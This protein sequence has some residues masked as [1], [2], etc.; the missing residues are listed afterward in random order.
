MRRFGCLL[1]VLVVLAVGTYAADQAIT[2]YAERQTAQ[3]LSSQFDAESSV[4]LTGWPVSLR[5]LAGTI[6]RAD[7]EL[8]DVALD[9]G[10]VLDELVVTLTDVEVSYQSLSAEGDALPPARSGTFSA[11]LSEGS[12]AGLLGVPESIVQ[13]ELGG[14]VVTMSAAGI[15]VEADVQA[16]D[17]DV[18][19]ALRGAIAQLLGA[20]ELTIDLSDQPGAPS[21]EEV[22]IGDGVLTVRGTLTEVSR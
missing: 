2:S 11:Q 21:V 17:G 15:E 7:V 4:D 3:R 8:R 13:V 22:E 10:A 19:F 20:G 1:L 9:N 5:M 18:A 6:P 16:V 12:V 14:G